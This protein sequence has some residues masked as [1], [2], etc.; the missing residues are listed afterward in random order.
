MARI[1]AD[2]HILDAAL[3]VITQQGYAGAT[4]RE[5]AAAAGINEVTLFRR[6]GSKQNLLLAAVEREAERFHAAELAYTGDL[7][8]DLL[9]IVR[10]YHNLVQNRGQM[11]A[12]LLTEAPRQPE[13][14]ALMQTPFT[15]AG[16]VSAILAR[17]QR[18]GALAAEP[19]VH[20]L[21]ALVGPLILA[22]LVAH[23]QPGLMEAP[24][25]PAAHVRRF[26]QGR[27]VT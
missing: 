9:R 15:I 7:D 11:M 23:V 10:F 22:E 3:D 14:L 24:P 13:L 18:E 4:T 25:D 27:A 20:A 17:Y 5:I 2:D 8:A 21:A 6:F 16:N 12:M 1:I 19:P 26:L